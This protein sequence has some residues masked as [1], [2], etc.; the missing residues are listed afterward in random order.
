[1]LGKQV[2]NP[3]VKRKYLNQRCHLNM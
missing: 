2:I 3:R 1:M